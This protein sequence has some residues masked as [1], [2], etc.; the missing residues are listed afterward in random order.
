MRLEGEILVRPPSASIARMVG[1]M[2]L[3]I[4]VLFSA[5]ILIRGGVRQ[6]QAALCLGAAAYGSY[7]R[8]A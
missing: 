7:T 8:G 1:K 3:G 5:Q 6:S 4:A 2:V